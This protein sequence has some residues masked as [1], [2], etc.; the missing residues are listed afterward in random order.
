MNSK[1]IKLLREQTGL[2]QKMFAERYDFSIGA[3]RDWEQGRK[4]PNRL[5]IKRLN[6]IKVSPGE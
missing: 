6:K 2:S 4:K 3:V 5:S 1:E